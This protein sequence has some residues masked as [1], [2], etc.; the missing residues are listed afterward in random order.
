MLHQISKLQATHLRTYG[1]QSAQ[2]IRLENSPLTQ[3]F[4]Q[5]NEQPE[6][7]YSPYK[8]KPVICQ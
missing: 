8:E 6:N 7:I 2:E 1:T 5:S 4:R 3:Y